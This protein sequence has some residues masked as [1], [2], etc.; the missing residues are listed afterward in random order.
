MTNLESVNSLLKIAISGE[1]AY[2]S[3]YKRTVQYANDSRAYFGGVNIDSY[4]KKFAR[5]EAEDLFKQRKEITAH[6]NKSLG[7]MLDRP[8]AKVKRS[9]W[10]KVI[11]FGKDEQGQVSSDFEKTVLMEFTNNGLDSYVFDRCRHFSKYDPNTFI[12]V[13]F[14]PFDNTKTKAKPYPFE[15]TSDMAVD[16]NFNEHG[17]LE[18]LTVRQTKKIDGDEQPEKFEGAKRAGKAETV[19]ETERLT[20]YRPFQTIVI[21]QLTTAEIKAL[22]SLPSKTKA[23]ESEPKN[24]Q[25]IHVEGGKVFTVI[26]PIPHKF[27]RTPA[28]RVGYE[29]SP[30][31]DG[32]TRVGIFDAALPYAKKVVKINSELDLT[33]ALLAFPVSIRHQESCG[34]MGY[35]SGTLGDGTTCTECHGTGLKKRPTSAAEEIVLPLPERPED[36]LDVSKIIHYAYPPTDAV[37]LQLELMT[38]NVTQAKES[39]F[40]SQMHT[41]QEVAQ[42]A[43]YHGIEL[44]SVYDTLFPYAQNL[45]KIWRFLSQCCQ[46]FTGY[47]DDMTAMLIFPKDFKFQALGSM[48]AELEQAIKS[49]VSSEARAIFHSRIME[50][51][52]IDDPEELE[53]W[54]IDER[55]NPFSGQSEQQIIVSLNLDLYPRWQ[56][57]WYSNRKYLMDIILQETPDFYKMKHSA[58]LAIVKAKSE[59]MMQ[60]LD[61]QQP[62]LTLN[63]PT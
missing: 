12:V 59:E 3:G 8:F 21:Q 7:A 46:S 60:E 4:L 24:G 41:K 31:D 36:M 18:Y 37:R 33:G 14:A 35:N 48:F 53:R 5:R 13:E 2:H 56:K 40:N 62:E 29:G 11:S 49:G 10:N 23:I 52:L 50:R 25:L 58:Q 1:K 44:E 42:T 20:M 30:E 39:V 19:K 38:H 54:R 55:L 17:T 45:G 61:A 28:I 22:P 34:A 57:V 16:Y 26:I 6:I 9:N 47:S 63:P 43:M 32:Q 15:V 27:N 51:V